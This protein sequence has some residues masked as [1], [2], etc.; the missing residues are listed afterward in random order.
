MLNQQSSILFKNLK[1]DNLDLFDHSKKLDFHNHHYLTNLIMFSYTKLQYWINVELQSK[2]NLFLPVPLNTVIKSKNLEG[3][4]HQDQ[5]D[6]DL[7]ESLFDVR[8][9]LWTKYSISAFGEIAA[10]KILLDSFKFLTPNF[11][12]HANI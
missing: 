5:Y 12:K 10:N 7:M 4:S 3:D 1:S 9:E 8:F 11:M 6:Y 2:P